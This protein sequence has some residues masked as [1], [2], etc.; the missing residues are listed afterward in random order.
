MS[1]LFLIIH[2]PNIMQGWPASRLVVQ[3]KY[4]RIE[5]TTSPLHSCTRDHFTLH[6]TT[7]EC[8]LYTNRH[9]VQDITHL[10]LLLTARIFSVVN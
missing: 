10:V 5:A 8:I 9:Y 2:N 3:V 1:L 7:K 6:L 4:I